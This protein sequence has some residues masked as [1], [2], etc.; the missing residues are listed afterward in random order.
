M[1]SRNDSPDSLANLFHFLKGEPV[2]ACKVAWRTRGS[3]IPFYVGEIVVNAIQPS[4]FSYGPTM[5][6]RL[7][8]KCHNFFGRK[9]A[10][11]YALIR[12]FQEN[13]SALRRFSIRSGNCFSLLFLFW[14]HVGPPLSAA[15]PSLLTFRMTGAAFVCYKKGSS[16]VS[17]KMFFCRRQSPLASVA[18]SSFHKESMASGE[19]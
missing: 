2:P 1:A 3:N 4:I 9:I 14:R 6:A 5:N 18:N 15:V 8:N 11:V 10:I 16:F 7:L 19:I 13:C 17:D 12:F